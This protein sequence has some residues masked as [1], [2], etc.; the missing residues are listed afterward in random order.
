LR[1]VY[2]FALTNESRGELRRAAPLARG[3][4]KDKGVAGIAQK[5]LDGAPSAVSPNGTRDGA[6]LIIDH[7]RN[8][9]L[10][11]VVGRAVRT[12]VRTVVRKFA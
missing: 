4:T 1:D 12:C 9:I 2:D 10:G 11:R 7:L 6:V 3:A 8:E 5:I